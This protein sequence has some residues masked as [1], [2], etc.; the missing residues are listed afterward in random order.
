MNR[1]KE[2]KQG[3]KVPSCSSNRKADSEIADT[4]SYDA[5]FSLGN[6]CACAMCMRR[7]LLRP[8]SGPFDWL[9]GPQRFLERVQAVEEQFRDWMNPQ[10]MVQV[11]GDDKMRF[12]EN[13]RTGYVFLHDFPA[14][15]PLEQSMPVVQERY[16]RRQR[17]FLET[18]RTAER[19]LLVWYNVYGTTPI[20]EIEFGYR[21]L[22]AAFGRPFDLLM[23]E[24][25]EAAKPGVFREVRLCEGRVT[26]R[27]SYL[28][29]GH[30]MYPKRGRALRLIDRGLVGYALRSD[31]RNAIRCRDRRVYLR[32]LAFRLVAAIVP[33][34]SVR[35]RIRNACRGQ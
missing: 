19:P 4:R 29:D 35:R 11:G 21:R 8:Y 31:L 1:K 24:H 28:T 34:R 9:G 20:D 14:S 17:R 23:L 25:D 15:E 27:I 30:G 33:I 32:R 2:T 3:Q 18:M 22:V 12:L 13:T 10:E 26:L 16:R 5:A 7:N 6:R